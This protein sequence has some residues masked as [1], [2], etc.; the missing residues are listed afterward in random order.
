MPRRNFVPKYR[1]HPNG[2]AFVCHSSIPTKDHRL[3]MG[4]YGTPESLARYAE[5]VKRIQS[6]QGSLPCPPPTSVPKVKDLVGHYQE[7]AK[8]YYRRGDGLSPEY[9]AMRMALTY[10]S[11]LFGESLAM[12]FG[13]RSLKDLQR[14]LVH[15][16]YARTHINHS[17]SRIKRF[18]RWAASEELVDPTMH[19]KLLCI[20]GLACGEHGAVEPDPVRPATPA[21][22]R[23]VLPFLSPIIRDMVQ[24]QYLCGMRPGEVC[25]MRPADIDQRND[26][27]LYRP[28][29]HKNAWRNK[30]LVKAIPLT[31]QEILAQRLGGRAPEQYLFSPQEAVQQEIDGRPKRERKTKLYPSEAARVEREKERASR[32]VRRKQPGIHYTVGSYSKAVKKGFARAAKQRVE[33]ESFSPN[34]LR[35]AILT[36][37]SQEFGEQKAQRYAGHERLETTGLYTEIEVKEIADVARLLDAHWRANQ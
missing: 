19:H 34:Q 16:K 35:H 9:E 32:R 3:Y 8:A 11:D 33:L 37:I 27:W 17:I 1:R 7:F 29:R 5:F 12:D 6:G 30:V 26:I 28:H 13:P 15:A 2:S 4:K 20:R 23:G 22:I 24:L 14:S 10:L 36:L 31:A 21:S 25:L 18:F